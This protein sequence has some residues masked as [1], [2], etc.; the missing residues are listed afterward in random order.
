MSEK[1]IIDELDDLLKPLAFTPQRTAWN[2]KV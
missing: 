2:P 1:V